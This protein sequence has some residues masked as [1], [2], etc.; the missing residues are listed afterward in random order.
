MSEKHLTELPWKTLVVKQGVKDIGLGKVLV[1]YNSVDATKE[2]AKALESLKEIVELAL[3]LK[4]ANQTKDEVV[5]H[6]E[7]MVKEVKKTT[8]VLEARLKSA[9]AVAGAATAQV[10]PAEAAKPE[11]AAKTAAE[12][13]DEEEDEEE[14]EAKEAAALKKDLKQKTVS[15]LAQVKARA[16]GDP[17]QQK[18]PKPQLQ[19]MAYL[20]G[21]NCAVVV[22]QRVGSATKKLLPEIAGGAGGG[23]FVKG[24]CIFEK[25]IHTFVLAKVPGGLAKQLATALQAETGQKYKVRVRSIDGSGTLDSD[26][27]VNPD[28]T[29]LSPALK[30]LSDRLRN[31]VVAI[32]PAVAQNASLRDQVLPA[33]NAAKAAL[34]AGEEA[35]CRALL[36]ALE[37]KLAPGAKPGQGEAGTASGSDGLVRK[38]IFIL[39]RWR[40]IP[41]EIKTQTAALAKVVASD[42]PHEDAGGFELALDRSLN[43]LTEAMQQRIDEALDASINQGDQGY[44]SVSATLKALRSEVSTNALIAA[45]RDNALA[46]ARGVELAY[47]SAFDE[48]EQALAA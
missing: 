26:T 32:K 23:Q 6:L 7:E 15:A 29:A 3:K 48:I 44:S 24:E 5:A 19:F 35:R 37:K 28:A 20:A 22:A 30:E 46:S 31:V 18:E 36:V 41:S 39:T 8:P 21:K 33:L 11:P 40:K 10:K 12:E 4:K 2:P 13:E 25:N 38:R 45:L 27:D 14:E 16:P 9:A 43:Q 47:L 34:D 1:A 17:E 42:L